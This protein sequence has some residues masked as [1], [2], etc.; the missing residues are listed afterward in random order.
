MDTEVIEIQPLTQAL[1]TVVTVPG[2]KSYTNRALL[3]AAL[4][5]GRSDLAGA[6]FSE[7]T[8]YM[9]Q[10]LERLGV[11]VEADP[12]ACRFIVGGTG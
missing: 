5:P 6:L 10:A 3:V 2:S 9:V 7:D 8:Q 4:A 11:V 12:Q 1:D